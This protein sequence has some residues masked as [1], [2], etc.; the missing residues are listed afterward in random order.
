ML[1]ELDNNI[2]GT[3]SGLV[4]E[5]SSGNFIWARSKW[6]IWDPVNPPEF[7]FGY[8]WSI[9]EYCFWSQS[10]S[11]LIQSWTLDLWI[12]WVWSDLWLSARW[13]IKWSKYYSFVTLISYWVYLQILK[14]TGW[15]RS[16]LWHL[17][18]FGITPLYFE[19]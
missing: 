10:G 15:N 19:I 3:N 12:H 4:T 7:N 11:D 1:K 8:S 16:L 17:T 13:D 14:C 9:F 18:K 2:L 6:R 5:Q